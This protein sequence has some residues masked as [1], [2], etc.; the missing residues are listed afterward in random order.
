MSNYTDDQGDGSEDQNSLIKGLRKQIASLEGKAKLLDQARE[1]AAGSVLEGLG[2]PGLKNTYLEKVQDF[3]STE[4]A[5]A[6]L[7]DLGL[8]AK[9]QVQVEDKPATDDG[10]GK[11]KE[12]ADISSLG[13]QAAAAATKSATDRA[14]EI[15]QKIRTAKN[16][17]ELEKVMSE[18][19][20]RTYA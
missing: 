6:F 10:D 2:F 5:K 12:I 1:Q 7:A 15:D 16:P 9:T 18:L 17:A 14:T 20:L 8:E 11:A 19:G 13:A 3:P 4:S